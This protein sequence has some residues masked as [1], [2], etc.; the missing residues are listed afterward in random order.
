[1]VSDFLLALFFLLLTSIYT[2]WCTI[3]QVLL[4]ISFN[5]SKNKGIHQSDRYL[6]FLM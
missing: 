4:K 6:Y 5:F 3:C 2:I 1:M